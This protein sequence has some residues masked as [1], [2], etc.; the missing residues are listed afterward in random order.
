MRV[1]NACENNWWKRLSILRKIL[2]KGWFDVIRWCDSLLSSLQLWVLCDPIRL[3]SVTSII[4]F[5]ENDVSILKTD[6]FVAKMSSL[7]SYMKNKN[8]QRWNEEWRFDTSRS[9]RTRHRHVKEGFDRSKNPKGWITNAITPSVMKIARG[10][11][12]N[13]YR[14]IRTRM[15]SYSA[16][17]SDPYVYRERV[18]NN[19]KAKLTAN[20]N[21][22]ADSPA[23]FPG[24]Y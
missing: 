7:M 5:K 17:E 20:V 21:T 18:W 3:Q 13:S 12:N 6:M 1:V 16:S 10:N 2:Y 19:A 23:W 22:R 24:A 15:R 11:F 4:S 8:I 14:G 9:D